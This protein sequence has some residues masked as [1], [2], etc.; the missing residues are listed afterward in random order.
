M[1]TE[2]FRAFLTGDD[3]TW[4][5]FFARGGGDRIVAVSDLTGASEGRWTEPE[6]DA[7]VIAVGGRRETPI[8]P[9]SWPRRFGVKL[10]GKRAPTSDIY[11]FPRAV[12]ES[13]GIAT[14][15]REDS[16]SGERDGS[17]SPPSG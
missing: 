9:W 11:L 16:L 3:I 15:T 4:N 17:P 10:L 5:V 6:V 2:E 13:L 1:D 12:A 14:G 8:D 7:L